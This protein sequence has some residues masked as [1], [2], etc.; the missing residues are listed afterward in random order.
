[1]L[2][3]TVIFNYFSK[4]WHRVAECFV[5]QQ[6]RFCVFL[7]DEAQSLESQTYFTHI[8]SAHQNVFDR[9]AT[10]E[11]SFAPDESLILGDSI[12]GGARK[13]SSAEE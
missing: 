5:A 4:G 13:L 3:N 10:L 12:C 7:I 2:S 9:L 1:M 6:W 11:G 8:A